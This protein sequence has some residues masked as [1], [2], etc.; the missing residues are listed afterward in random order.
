MIGTFKRSQ[1]KSPTFPHKRRIQLPRVDYTPF[2]LEFFLYYATLVIDVSHGG[3]GW[4]GL[5]ISVK[6]LTFSEN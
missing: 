3:G 2:P 5:A 4:G 6:K 1:F